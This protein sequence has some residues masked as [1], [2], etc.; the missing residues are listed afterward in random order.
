MG[1]NTVKGIIAIHEYLQTIAFYKSMG[2]AV[3][4]GVVTYPNIK[5]YRKIKNL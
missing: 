4:Y 5:I 3:L 1:Y 2:Y